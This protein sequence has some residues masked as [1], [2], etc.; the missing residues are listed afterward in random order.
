MEEINKKYELIKTNYYLLCKLFLLGVLLAEIALGIRV[1]F[2]S[3]KNISV[4]NQKEVWFWIIVASYL[5]V[6]GTFFFRREVWRQSRIIIKSRRIDLLIVFA[7]G[8]FSTFI[9]GG[10][11]IDFFRRWVT[12]LSWLH[13]FVLLLFPIV[14]F[15]AIALR[16]LQIKTIKKID[17]DSSF[18]SDREGQN[19]NDDAFEFFETAKRFADRVHNNG[20]S[21][22]LVF[23]IDA[24]WGT[25]KSTFVNLCQEHWNKNY[26][27]EIIV[28]TFDPLR[29]EN[30]DNILEKFVD[31]LLKV[32]KDNFFVPELESLISKY[33]KLLNDAKLTF[34]FFGIRFGVPFDNSSID[35]TFEKLE[36]V[37]RSIDKKIVIVVDDLDR[38]NFSSIKE[39][40]FVIK[41]SFILP[42]ISYV[43]CYDTEN[44]TALEHQKLDTEKIIE[45]LEKF[46][47]IKTS[48][49]LDHKLL[50]NYFTEHK[51]ESL[52]RN[53]LSNPEVVSK[54]VE[55]LKDI[56]NSNEYYLYI[57]FVGDA[58]KLKRLVNTILLLEVEQLDFSNTDLDKHDLIHLLIIYINYPNIFRKIYNTEAQGKRG[59]FSL[60]TKYDDDYPIDTDSHAKEDSFKN[61][62]K[63]T[64]YIESLT[65]NQ[66][67]IL[68]KIFDVNQRLKAISNISQEQLTSYACFNGSHWGS[69]SRNL[70]QYLNLIIKLSRPIHT[71]QY[72][73]YVN[74]KNEILNQKNI[75]EVLKREEFSFSGGEKNHEQI[76]RVLINSPHNEFTSEKTKEILLYLLDNLPHYSALKI[77]NFNVG[78][79]R[80][81]LIF[82]IV[83]L[84]D[85]VGW[86]DEDGSHWHNSNDN[87][88]EIAEWIFGE[89]Q[90]SQIGILER[91]AKKERGIL[92]LHDL[93][94]FRLYCCADRGGDIF[95]LSRALSKHGGKSNPIEGNE[96][97]I[98]IGEMRE[99]SQYIFGVFKERYI[100]KNKNIFEEVLELSTEAICGN[101]Y[102]FIKSKISNSELNRR[103]V[104][105]KSGLLN[106]IIYQLGSTIYSSGIPCGYYDIEDDK[107]KHGIKECVNKY[108][109]ETC[110]N[111]KKYEKGYDYFLYFL[112]I[113]LQNTF[114][115]SVKLIPNIEEFAKVLDKDRIRVYWRTHRSIIQIKESILT[116]VE[117]NM[118]ENETSYT[119][120]LGDIYKVLDE[121]LQEDDSL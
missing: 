91:M 22:S 88:L 117:F 81:T 48:L 52:A 100:D 38:L 42:N 12:S 70:E 1:I 5:L 20:S 56:F 41:K 89:N 109:F 94:S 114:G 8:A 33:V 111:P 9:L 113:N 105:L 76:W 47:N 78:L 84:L 3:F 61:S 107:D 19:V 16:S 27:D 75:G 7:L 69:N 26:K 14:F 98:V 13:M 116:D 50:L 46:I 79:R 58:R 2:L 36:S 28:Y 97:D 110:F 73:F 103:L 34:S 54:A 106:F 118:S 108:L 82:F 43:L 68:N 31:G 29:F 55:G 66:K 80:H 10:L 62:T 23:G 40:L 96:R 92:G 30:S 53:L 49:Y 87:V 32:I 21:E 65:E 60:I 102:D 63:Y 120:R 72:R 101:S 25:G 67:F 24:P 57:P 64:C 104:G 119:D 86:I 6:A 18:M 77:E 39:I 112:I 11:W 45:F 4:E 85:K 90:Y 115:Y 95:N 93:L 83:K 59:F 99:I 71:E 37:L 15:T 17:K 35:K 51:D 44:I 121:L 74:I